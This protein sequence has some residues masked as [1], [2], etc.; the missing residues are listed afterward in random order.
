MPD[1]ADI[2]SGFFVSTDTNN[3]IAAAPAVGFG[4]A[5]YGTVT[6]GA[7]SG[8]ATAVTLNAKCGVVTMNNASLAAST[9]VQFTMTN[10]AISAT[11][12]VIA[13][14]GSGGTAGSY[15]C[16]VVSVGA[17]TSVVRISNTSG[18]SLSEAVTINFAVID[19]SAT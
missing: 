4:P 8:K 19:T 3:R 18:G 13:N 1:P 2:P 5:G 6:Q 10:S 16:H 17:G 12:V 9:A 11:D 7:G 14:Q 15:Q